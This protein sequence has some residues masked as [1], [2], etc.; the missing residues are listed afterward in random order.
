M[1][2]LILL[3]AAVAAALVAVGARLSQ[4]ELRA[5]RRS[6]CA[7]ASPGEKKIKL[8]GTARAEQP[9]VSPLREIPCIFYALT[10]RRLGGERNGRGFGDSAHAHGDITVSSRVWTNWWLEDDSGLLEVD[11]EGAEVVTGGAVGERTGGRA[12]SRRF[13]Q[14]LR[15][16]GVADSYLFDYAILEEV[17]PVDSEVFVYGPVKRTPQGSLLC[18]G[19][20]LLVSTR[21][22][23]ALLARN[24][25][26]TIVAAAVAGA[27]LLGALVTG[28]ELL[29]TQAKGEPQLQQYQ[30]EGFGMQPLE[31]TH[32]SP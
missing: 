14:V 4:K 21:S 1:E 9:L 17:I 11:G 27:A 16:Y 19:S 22:E 24:A 29:D 23:K 7:A 12:S 26:V 10:I 3:I 2:A 20:E 8:S 5:C 30:P 31:R 28:K 6:T 18:G 13:Q 15:E 32:P 25:A